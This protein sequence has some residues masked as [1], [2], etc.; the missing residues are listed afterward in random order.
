MEEMYR[1]PST[2]LFVRIKNQ[3]PKSMLVATQN[4]KQ[5]FYV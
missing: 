3:K 1:K 2:G 5:F 4:D